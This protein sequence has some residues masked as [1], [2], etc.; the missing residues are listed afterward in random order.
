MVRVSFRVI[1]GCDV[2]FN[3][4]TGATDKLQIV[5]SFFYPPCMA[6]SLNTTIA[7]K[8]IKRH[9]LSLKIVIKKIPLLLLQM[10]S[11]MP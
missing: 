2:M 9:T 7:H 11:V 10:K 6:Q 3:M 4:S 5:M 8:S 1:K